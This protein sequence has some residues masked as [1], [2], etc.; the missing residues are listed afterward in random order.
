LQHS[1][2]VGIDGSRH[3]DKARLE[4]TTEELLAGHVSGL[5]NPMRESKVA[6]ISIQNAKEQ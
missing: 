1:Y 2:F 3:K 4:N 6:I 5:A